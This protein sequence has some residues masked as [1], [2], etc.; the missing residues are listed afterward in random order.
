MEPE[1][2]LPCS[3]QPAIDP[4]PEPD[5]SS[6][7]LPYFPMIHSKIILS[8]TIRS[9]KPKYCMHSS[10]PWMFQWLLASYQHTVYGLYVGL[11]FL[12]KYCNESCIFLKDHCL[13]NTERRHCYSAPKIR[14]ALTMLRTEIKIRAFPV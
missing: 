6:P 9:S 2:S 3:Q 8:S 4:Y 7:H 1:G 14:F 11:L 5:A 12:S 10:L 13:Y